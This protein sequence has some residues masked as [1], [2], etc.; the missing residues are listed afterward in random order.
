MN[1]KILFP[2]PCS[3]CSVDDVLAKRMKRVR[4]RWSIAR[5]EVEEEEEITDGESNL[6][7]SEVALLAY[8]VYMKEVIVDVVK[9]ADASFVA[10]NNLESIS[11]AIKVTLE[12]SKKIY[13]FIDTA[14]NAT[15]SEDSNGNLS[16][17]VY[18]KVSEL[19]Q[20][21]DD[22]IGESFPVFENFLTQMLSGIPEAQF[23]MDHD[24]I[25]TSNADIVY[26]KLAIKLIRE[27]PKVNI[28]MF[29]WWSVIEDLILYTT[30][31][32]RE[33]YNQYLKLVTGVD[34]ISSRSA[35]CTSSVN[36]LMG[37]AVSHLILE[38][39]FITE[40]KPKVQQMIENIR[41]SFN[42]LV[43]HTTWMDW[44]TKEKTL[45]KSQKMKSFI[46]FPDWVQ[47]RTSLDLHYK[48]VS[49]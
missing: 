27:T 23:L 12:L 2:F 21:I 17:L 10:S 26:L 33:M 9:K 47:N 16:D 32:M 13:T 24:V 22:D 40:T 43:L 25:L 31:H 49:I 4:R 7:D 6:S 41:R 48:G 45:K 30:T 18:L 35:Y 36:R 46:G 37:F 20:I 3:S 14:E 42:T 11:N 8:T 44:K 1:Y 28:E 19:Q 39:N 38:E 5:S 29:I 34:G 15:K